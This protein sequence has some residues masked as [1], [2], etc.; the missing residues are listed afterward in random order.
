MFKTILVPLDLNSEE[1]WR[2]PLPLAVEMARASG[3]TLHFTTVVPDYG[4]ALVQSHF[5][6]DFERTSLDQA[7]DE[8]EKLVAEN[9]PDDVTFEL[10]LE[11]G[12]IRTHVLA[13]AKE[14]GADLILM[15]SQQPDQFREFLVGSHADWIVRHSPISVFVVRGETG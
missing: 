13:R 12:A 1:S 6:K 15:A 7:R 10:H 4:A 2:K 5:P 8:M 3:G 9:V 14:V 11:H